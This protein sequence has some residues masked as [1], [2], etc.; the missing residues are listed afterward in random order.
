ME[1]EAQ[2]DCEKNSSKMR[3]TNVSF[4]EWLRVSARVLSW[5]TFPLDRASSNDW[6]SSDSRAA[7]LT[8]ASLR[9][10]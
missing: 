8:F 10:P 2:L 6:A 5:A 3:V 4:A 1:N 9:I 7:F